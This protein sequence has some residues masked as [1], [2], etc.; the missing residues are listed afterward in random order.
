MAKKYS[1]S[2]QQRIQLEEELDLKLGFDKYD[3][4]QPRIGWLFNMTT[5]MLEDK[6]NIR[7]RSAVKYYFFEEDGGLFTCTRFYNPYFY[8]RCK[9]GTHAEVASALMKM[10][11]KLIYKIVEEHKK[12]DLKEANHLVASCHTFLKL[13]FRNVQDLVDSRWMMAHIRV[14]MW[15]VV[16]AVAREDGVNIQMTP[17]HER[18]DR[19]DLVVLAFDIETTKLPLMFPDAARD[20]IMMVSYMIDGMGF[21]II[22][23]EVV[24]EDIEPFAYSPDRDM[25]GEFK[26][27]N[28][29]NERTML[30]RFFKEIRKYKPNIIVTYNG[31]NFDWPFVE[32][33]AH[34]YGINMRSEIGFYCFDEYYISK[35]CVHIDCLHWV[36]RDSYLP[37]GSH[38]LKAVAK[39]KL[40]YNPD[41][42]DPEVMT[43][44][45]VE[46]PQTLAQY[47][48]SDAVATY[49][50]YK[51]Y[52][53]P[54]IFSLCNI[55]PLNPDD[56]LRKGSGTLCEALLMVSAYKADIMI[57][58]KH[59]DELHK[60]TAGG[61]DGK[62]I[63]SET[64]VGGHVE[65]LMAGVYRCDLPVD[66]TINSDG[67]DKL[68]ASVDQTLR[69]GIE[70][71]WE[72]KL[73]E[74]ADYEEVKQSVIRT[75]EI[76][77]DN[78]PVL[79]AEPLIYHLDVAAMY[80][81]IILTNR[82]QPDSIVSEN[83]CAN[84]DF[85]VPGKTCDRR[86]KWVWRGEVWPTDRGEYKSILDRLESESF[87]GKTSF[88]AKRNWH[89][90]TTNEQAKYIQERLGQ[91]S[92]KQYKKKKETMSEQREAIVCQRERPFYVDTV[93]EFRDRR[94]QYK[95]LLKTSKQRLEKAIKNR[96]VS[97]IETA[98][99]EIILY[100]SLQLAHKCI[101]NSFYG[102]VM[103]KGARWY[104]M[105]MGG[106]VCLTGSSIIQSAKELV[107][108]VGAALELDTDG[109]WCIFPKTFPENV[110]FTLKNGEKLNVSFPC[111][112]LN[113]M[114]HERYTNEQ[115]QELV[116]KE[117]HEY[118]TR[119][120][121]SIFFEVDGPYRAMILPAST[122]E[123]KLLKKRYAVFNH[124]GSLA[125]LKGFEVKRRGELKLIK[126]F[127]ELV[128]DAFL[129]GKT[130]ED[131]YQSAAEIANAW[132]DILESEARDHP[133][134][135]LIDMI[136]EQKSM[137]RSLED[138]GEQKSTAITAAKRLQEFFG[139][140]DDVSQR[141]IP[142]AI[143]SASKEIKT[144][145][146]KKWLRNTNIEGDI[147]IRD[148][149]DWDYYK[150][151]LNATIQRLITIPAG[152][153]NI[154]NPVPRVSNPT[155]LSKR[156]QN[157]R[158]RL[159]TSFF[160][161][162]FPVD[163]NS[164][165]AKVG[166]MENN[167]KNVGPE[168]NENENDEACPEE[169]TLEPADDV[170]TIAQSDDDIGQKQTE[171]GSELGM[172]RFADDRYETSQRKQV[173]IT[174]GKQGI[175]SDSATD[176][177]VDTLRRKL[178]KPSNVFDRIT[179]KSFSN[180]MNN[181]P[182]VYRQRFCKN[183]DPFTNYN[184]WIKSICK[185]RAAFNDWKAIHVIESD[186]HGEL[187]KWLSDGFS[188]RR[189]RVKTKD[190]ENTNS[191]G[192][193][194]NIN[195]IIDLERS[196]KHLIGNEFDYL[197]INHTM[198]DDDHQM[199]AVFSSFSDDAMIFSVDNLRE[200]S[201]WERLYTQ[202]YHT[203]EED[204][205]EVLQGKNRL[206]VYSQKLTFD[207]T[208]YRNIKQTLTS[209]SNQLSYCKE[210]QTRPTIVILQ[211]PLALR[212][213]AAD[214]TALRDFPVLCLQPDMS[215]LQISVDWRRQNA[216][217]AITSFLSLGALLT[218]RFEISRYANVPV[219]NVGDDWAIFCL[220]V[221]LARRLK[222]RGFVDWPF[223]DQ[224]MPAWQQT[225]EDNLRT[226]RQF[227][228]A[229]I[230][231][232]GVYTTICVAMDV[233]NLAID[234]IL[235]YGLDSIP[236]VAAHKI[237]P[238]IRDMLRELRAKTNPGEIQL[239]TK[240][241]NNFGRWVTTRRSAMYDRRFDYAV[242]YLMYK[243][244]KQLA[245]EFSDVGCTVVHADISKFVLAT[246][247]TTLENALPYINQ[248]EDIVSK[249]SVFKNLKLHRTDYWI[250]LQWHDLH[251]YGGILITNKNLPAVDMHWIIAEYLP[252]QIRQQFNT[253]I[254]AYIKM[255]WQ[256]H[257][258]PIRQ[259]ASVIEIFKKML[260]KVMDNFHKEEHKFEFPRIPG[261]PFAKST[262]PAAEF[263]NVICNIFAIDEELRLEVMD[264]RKK[265]MSITNMSA[266]AQLAGPIRGFELVR[267]DCRGC[268][269]S[270]NL[271]FARD[272]DLVS[273]ERKASWSCTQCGKDYERWRIEGALVELVHNWLSGRRVGKTGED[274]RFLQWL[275]D[276]ADLHQMKLLEEVVG[277]VNNHL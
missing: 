58:H 161:E 184:A 180:T 256:Q 186:V 38:G 177:S 101:L 28:E 108:R 120:E 233:H 26:I 69:F 232:P 102:Y 37:V 258:K 221:F 262:R 191:I 274:D 103:R 206:F 179:K 5:T 230:N 253:I 12:Q 95:S 17:I 203:F 149:L 31:D 171:V 222:K 71:E 213:L 234:A 238:I 121:N 220:D 62:L 60:F 269:A 266:H 96:D 23:R 119:K 271:D 208:Y 41:E 67:I 29:K 97:E 156:S 276:L 275:V 265:L 7:G 14:G 219:C 202:V 32:R 198:L 106:V 247:K 36:R 146:L 99:Q 91:Y 268:Y 132:V 93:R 270:R 133:D 244:A 57:P 92:L 252:H 204:C 245:D 51:K 85:N 248:A 170:V 68:I 15:Y 129:R 188:I 56:I 80:P 192:L 211:S 249:K 105:E 9:D 237:L 134:W 122:E 246:K 263:A 137:S 182:H 109:I 19:P 152:L 89:Q 86:M 6:K 118:K 172:K 241:F 78:N 90:L 139:K 40:G 224:K 251:N 104:S 193:P 18:G 201:I 175:S 63:Q 255:A 13:I 159:I 42:L 43:R 117:T 257:S 218:E 151:R 59:G 227:T 39:A 210:Q 128:F 107:E 153:Q 165:K 20:M 164:H 116:N 277:F 27:F 195:H 138:Y 150:K 157:D 21:L 50:L 167:D 82:L 77:R 81:N 223:P 73:A 239:T 54:F 4:G 173:K 84:C 273:E 83:V 235:A 87:P 260:L 124:D 76:I 24:A 72:K 228:D 236:H 47:S 178:R 141:A 66:F 199:F 65:A 140:D 22:N 200:T 215:D 74:I 46:R 144:A 158:Q 207:V 2:V 190:D 55:I 189:R 261:S 34:E 205:P 130:L 226:G 194:A 209:I 127:Q 162:S 10:F 216:R 110:T 155:W 1:S 45:A 196:R 52:V 183:G 231:A 112:M 100:D 240:L 187:I 70:T 126:V 33:R 48:V 243:A 212:I 142:I 123:N 98:R 181:K 163:L 16:E 148:I 160:A 131:C 11:D 225:S 145:C 254:T 197:Y 169:S 272:S 49:Y 30:Q 25:I 242:H 114:V 115:Y 185:R 136:C 94:Y 264:L 113:Q 217:K 53:H 88:D 143:F 250:Y 259:S 75:L 44:F 147:D 166:C 61:P 267:I 79:R 168:M 35:Q 8:V 229:V 3:H 154:V 214:L 111:A 64:Y 125:E 174:H 176:N 135:Y